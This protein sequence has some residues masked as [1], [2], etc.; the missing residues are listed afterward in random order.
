[1]AEPI[2]FEPTPARTAPTAREE[3]ERLL[4]TLHEHGVLRLANDVV[5]RNQDIARI[6]VQGL[7]SEAARNVIQN[8]SA[9]AMVLGRIPPGA[10]YK[11]A[12]ALREAAT[13]LEPA[14]G[15]A[16]RAPGVRGIYRLLND[17]EVWRA[18]TPLVRAV[19]RFGNAVARPAPDK[20]I[21]AHSG[22]ESDA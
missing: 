2:D 17:D 21:S 22:K 4:Q 11:I 13:A 12:D 20:P 9:V 16:V 18:L 1:M 14:G 7:N 10:V 5:A 8:V 3:W 19:G 6:V 15:D